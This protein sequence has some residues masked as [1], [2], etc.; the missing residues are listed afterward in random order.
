MG[1]RKRAPEREAHEKPCSKRMA[2]RQDVYQMHGRP[3]SIANQSTAATGL[4]VED[5]DSRVP[6]FCFSRIHS[7]TN[8][9]NSSDFFRREILQDVAMRLGK[10]THLANTTFTSE[11][12]L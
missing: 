11:R 8:A 1:A 12:L 7:R 5:S 3:Q 9:R 10:L 4:V 6:I 2:K